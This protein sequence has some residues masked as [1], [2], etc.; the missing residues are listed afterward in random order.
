MIRLGHLFSCC[1]MEM[2]IMEKYKYIQLD[3]K[4]S[5]LLGLENLSNNY[6]RVLK[7]DVDL[8]T[9]IIYIY[10]STKTKKIYI[11]QT[12]NFIQRHAQHYNGSDEKFLK[13]KF[14]KVIV[15]L[16]GLFNGSAL[17]D[18]EG[19]LITYFNADSA[20]LRKANVLYDNIVIN[21]NRGNKTSAY[22]E[23]EKI[24]C[25]VVL[26]FWEKVLYPN[27]WVSTPTLEELKNKALVKYS[28]IKTLTNEQDQLITEIIKNPKDNYVING[29]AGTGKTVLLTNLV[30]RLLKEKT[31]I[32]I[33][34]VVQKNWIKTGREIFKIFDISSNN[35]LVATS[36]TIINS[37]KT[38][39]VI[40]VDEAHK[41]SRRGNKQ[42]SSFNQ[43]YKKQKYVN[44]ESHLE[45]LQKL[46]KQIILMYDVLQAIRPANISRDKFINLTK[47]YR[48]R[49]L[50]A[51][52][53][54]QTTKEKHYTAEDYINGIKHLLY[55]DT[56]LLNSKL[57]LFNP[58]FD[59]GVFNDHSEEAYFGYY[60][61]EPIHNIMK[62]LEEDKIFHPEHTNRLL[63]GLVEKWGIKDGK[64]INKKHFIEGDIQMR[65]NST[66]NDWINIKDKDAEEQVGSVFAVQGIDLN[67]VGVLIG[68]DLQVNKN[69]HLYGEPK[70][71][72]NNNCKFSRKDIANLKN[73]FEFTLFVLNMYYVLLTRGIDG[74]RIGFWKNEHFQKYLEDTLTIKSFKEKK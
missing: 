56:G 14:D 19:Q 54:I 55:K 60:S 73:K 3:V 10:K 28:P 45:I 58:N 59:R 16:S 24:A 22:L 63:A 48:K 65:W 4:N 33:G 21:G 18:V 66:Q 50:T 23:K 42:M 74:V 72:L 15:L 26:P 32:Q 52:F 49:F 37:G 46:G 57:T 38:F 1:L 27:G 12:S 2:A 69:G 68:D 44:C 47:N 51:Q 61:T 39:D 34:V 41:L 25:D 43:V 8:N 5:Q 35:L 36:T 17:D 29:D 67:K 6:R 11:G 64:N 71:L 53:R 7:G 31:K 9:N 70:N 62:W 13:A 30:A 20:N 40:I